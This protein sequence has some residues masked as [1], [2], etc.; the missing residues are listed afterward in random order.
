MKLI[1]E[2]KQK[3]KD[4]VN[5]LTRLLPHLKEMR[6]S[7]NALDFEQYN[8]EVHE[9]LKKNSN[10]E[11]RNI[12]MDR[13]KEELKKIGTSNSS[14]TEPMIKSFKIKMERFLLLLKKI[15]SGEHIIRSMDRKLQFNELAYLERSKSFVV[16]NEA[17]T[18]I[19]ES[20]GRLYMVTD[21]EIRMYDL[22]KEIE[23]LG[24]EVNERMKGS[25]FD[26]QFNQFF[27]IGPEGMQVNP[28]NVYGW[29][30]YLE[31]QKKHR[32]RTKSAV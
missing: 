5:Q 29:F 23:V 27:N 6:E 12:I 24:N 3:V 9:L 15:K 10:N 7:Y 32:D 17:I 18:E 14:I 13:F 21:D 16:S 11:L 26:L 19:T 20:E 22:L 2:D 4:I 30:R 31:R 1:H 8:G 25:K 28:Q